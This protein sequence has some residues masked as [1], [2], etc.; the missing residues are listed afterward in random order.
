MKSFMI[1]VIIP[2]LII[3]SLQSLGVSYGAVWID[4]DDFTRSNY[5]YDCW[6][7]VYVGAYYDGQH[8]VTDTIIYDNGHGSEDGIRYTYDYFFVPGIIEDEDGKIV[9]ADHYGYAF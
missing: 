7:Y 2:I 8:I 3:V 4:D 6:T 1:F 5:V 9:G